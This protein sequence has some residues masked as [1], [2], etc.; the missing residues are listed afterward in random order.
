MRDPFNFSRCVSRLLAGAIAASF[1]HAVSS[2]TPPCKQKVEPVSG[3]MGYKDRGYGCEGFIV[4][5][6]ANLNIQVL[7]L[8]QGAVPLDAASTLLIGVPPQLPDTLATNTTVFGSGMTAGMNWALD[9]SSRPGSPM[10]WSVTTVARSAG[11]SATSLGLF[12]RAAS[13][14]RFATPWYVAV[15]V[16]ETPT[17]FDSRAKSPNTPATELVVRIPAASAIQYYIPSLKMWETADAMD[18][19][20]RFKC[21]IPASER[22][23]LELQL[24]WR[25][26]GTRT[27]SDVETLR[28]WLW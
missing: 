4:Q 9:G 1:P 19:D 5:P 10:K 24:K 27:W 11:L 16:A 23:A 6:Q 7:S 28:L 18:G 20:G 2:Q 15:R 25:P 8:I 12:A 14:A 17:A 22:D 13:S 21:V 26:R 3:S